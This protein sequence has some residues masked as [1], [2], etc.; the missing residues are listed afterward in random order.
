MFDWLLLSFLF[1]FLKK[2]FNR[3]RLYKCI[4][5]LQESSINS[6]DCIFDGVTVKS[7][8]L[9]LFLWFG[10]SWN[11]MNTQMSDSF[12]MGQGGS[13]NSFIETS[14]W[15]MFLSNNNLSVSGINISNKSFNIQW[16]EWE[17]INNSDVD[18]LN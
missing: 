13:A 9:Q 18:I 7:M 10:W 2:K 4:K 6:S 17:N 11:S 14:F 16:F 1:I 15:I 3:L 12:D 5:Q 8:H